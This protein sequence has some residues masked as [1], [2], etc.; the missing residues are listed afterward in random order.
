MALAAEVGELVEIFQWLTEE[1]SLN[2]PTSND[3]L[4]RVAEELADILIYVAR[5]ADVL[6]IDMDSAVAS[7]IRTN[8][9]R[10][11]VL[12]SKGTAAKYNRRK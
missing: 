9:A 2:L 4:T 11:P 5:L 6:A 12:L 1:Q 7:K 8:E 10:Y 3:D